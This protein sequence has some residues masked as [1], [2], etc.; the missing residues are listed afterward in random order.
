ME[1][2]KDIAEICQEKNSIEI[3]IINESSLQIPPISFS[4]S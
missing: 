1:F 4:D 2:E 3:T